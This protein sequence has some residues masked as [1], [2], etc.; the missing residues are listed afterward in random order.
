MHEFGL[1]KF[2][3]G[4]ARFTAPPCRL[5]DLHFFVLFGRMDVTLLVV[6]QKANARQVR[7]GEETVVGRSPEC[8][9]RIASGQVSRRHCVIKIKG[10]RVVVCDLGSAN[11]TEVDGQMIPPDVDIPVAPGST[12]VVG[13]LKFVFDFSPTSSEMRVLTGRPSTST[14]D[15]PSLLV[16]GPP[17]EEETKDF[18]PGKRDHAQAKD[19]DGSGSRAGHSSELDFSE[20]APT[21]PAAMLGR[22]V[23]VHEAPGEPSPDDTLYDKSLADHAREAALRARGLE[24]VS[25]AGTE[26]MPGGVLPATNPAAPLPAFDPVELNQLQSDQPDASKES[27]ADKKKWSLLGFLKRAPKEPVEPETDHAEK[28]VPPPPAGKSAP[29]G[30]DQEL[31]DFFKN[32]DG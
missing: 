18:T 27:A 14:T 12:L 5:N 2:P 21:S 17:P 28:P 20:G 26:L 3:I 9:L 24:G 23:N 8:N 29:R 4:P 1:G 15:L 25:E 6:N 32:L 16:Q 31:Q 13:P 22:E 10:P 30:D 7:L 11:G 19:S